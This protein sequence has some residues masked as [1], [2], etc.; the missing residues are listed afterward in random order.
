V[1][2]HADE[3]SEPLD[4]LHE[5][6][7]GRVQYLPLVDS[8]LWPPRP[9]PPPPALS[10]PAAPNAI[11]AALATC[12]QLRPEPAPGGGAAAA[13]PS[14]AVGSCTA[15][16]PAVQP[17]PGL[18]DA[19]YDQASWAGPREPVQPGPGEAP[20]SGPDDW[21][22]QLRRLSP[23]AQQ[24]VAQ[25]AAAGAAAASLLLQSLEPLLPERL[26]LTAMQRDPLDGSAAPELAGA[27]AMEA[28]AA[29]AGTS[30]A[31]ATSAA[32]AAPPGSVGQL[33]AQLQAHQQ[34]QRRLSAAGAVE[35]PFRGAAVGWR[36]GVASPMDGCVY[37]AQIESYSEGAGGWEGCAVGGR[38]GWRLWVRGACC[39]HEGGACR[40][41]ACCLQCPQ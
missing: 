14:Q 17:S 7:A 4:L 21:Q 27:A 40:R 32:S 39:G 36:V 24:P 37:Y 25:A 23:A 22:V 8:C 30:A 1:W 9:Q 13:A 5:E 6:A 15:A 35:A 10:T 38:G 18:D 20:G 34:R 16:G 11:D 12:A 28:A 31:A 3:V 33:L 26:R 2:Y 41:G 19:A 29:A